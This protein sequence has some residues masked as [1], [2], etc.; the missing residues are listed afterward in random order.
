MQNLR[1]KTVPDTSFAETYSNLLSLSV[2]RDMR[3]SQKSYMLVHDSCFFIYPHNCKAGSFDA[4]A[5]VK[6]IKFPPLLI[7]KKMF[8]H[9]KEITLYCCCISCFLKI[10]KK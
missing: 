8:G 3:F 6:S 9:P 2:T 7:S 5:I 10:I 4:P 1:K